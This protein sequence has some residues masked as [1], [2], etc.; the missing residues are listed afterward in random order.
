[1]TAD[2][3]APS[4]F[5]LVTRTHVQF[6]PASD[7][8]LDLDEFQLLS[9]RSDIPSLEQAARLYRGPFLD[10]LSIADS[11]A[12]EDWMLLQ[13]EEIRRSVLSLLDRLAALQLSRGETGQ[14]ARWARRQLELEP[15]R[16]QAHRQLMMALAL[17]GERSAALAHYEACR[18]LLANELGCEPEDETQALYTQIRDGSLQQPRLS[19]MIL[20]E[21]F[22]QPATAAGAQPALAGLPQQVLPRQRLPR[23]S[24]PAWKSWPNWAVCSTRRW[25]AGA[26]WP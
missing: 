1:M 12:F 22:G 16:E 8:W 20:I 19:P 26:G 15:Y 18:R 9:S 23:A 21:S 3:P 6:N 17:G 14:A 11:P 25:L 13:G 10:G 4:P 24:S 2:R 7:H 5:L